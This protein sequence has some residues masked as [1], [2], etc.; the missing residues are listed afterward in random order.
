[1]PPKPQ[2]IRDPLHNI[3]EFDTDQFEQTLWT[4][5]QTVPFQRL[6]RIKQ[7]GFSDFVYPGATHTRFAHCIGTFH[8]ARRLMQIIKRHLER[9]GMQV[10]DHQTQVA[11][12]ASLVH[13]VG[14]GMFSHAFEEIGKKLNLKMARHELVTE[15]LIGDG[16]IAQAFEPLG[17][18]FAKDV[19]TVIGQDGPRTLYDAVVTSQFDADRLDYMQ[20][21]RLMAGVQNSGI[22][23]AWLIDNLEVG[24]IPQVVDDEKGGD[25]E[26]FVLGP[27]AIYAAETFV[28]ALFQLYPTVYLHKTTRAA[29]KVFSTLMLHLIPLVQGGHADKTGLPVN[30]PIIRFA[31][32]S[33]LLENAIALDDMVF[34]GALPMMVEADDPAVKELAVRLHRRQL[35]KCIDIRSSLIDSLG[36][37]FV[38]SKDSAARLQKATILIEERLQ[39]WNDNNS[40]SAPRILIDRAHRNPYRQFQET[41][42][43]LNQIRI[44]TASGK[45]LDLAEHSPVVDALENFVLFRA[46]V[47]R[48]DTDATIMVEQTMNQV[49]GEK[50]DD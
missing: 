35:P 19:A 48:L 47:D 4:V 38:R 39:E 3:I 49:L 32:N 24:T 5:I 17:S 16:E 27:K 6:R 8:T 20:R 1:M 11:L 12:A 41:K 50:S 40:S 37:R 43:P 36:V 34:M 44:R 31:L 22:D 21:D 42:G 25:I 9:N 10:Q 46:Y 28:L 45:I 18:G 7:L 2:R 29:E 14:H 15:Q 23:F 13:D 30:H 33:D 26:T